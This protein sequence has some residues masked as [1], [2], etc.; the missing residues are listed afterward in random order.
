MAEVMAGQEAARSLKQKSHPGLGGFFC[1]EVSSLQL[2]WRSGRRWGCGSGFGAFLGAARAA[3][4]R[5]L[6]SGTLH[7]GSALLA[8]F[9]VFVAVGGGGAYEGKQ[10]EGQQCVFHIGE[11]VKSGNKSTKM[12]VGLATPS[13]RMPPTLR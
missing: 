9:G 4:G 8:F 5:F 2:Y 1:D 11:A 13:F 6:S 12:A 3:H 7:F 10:G